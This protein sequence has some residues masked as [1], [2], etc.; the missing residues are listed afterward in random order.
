MLKSSQ[1]I[2]DLSYQFLES[3][4][5]K[6]RQASTIKRYRYDLEDFFQ[7]IEFANHPIDHWAYFNSDTIQSYIHHLAFEKKNKHRTMKRVLT[8]LNQLYLYLISISKIKVNPVSAVTLPTEL[9][10]TF[11]PHE[12]LTASEMNKITK[13]AASFKGLSDHQ[14]KARKYLI[15]RNQALLTLFM[16]YGLSLQEAAGL[17]MKHVHFIQNELM[18]ESQTSMS[19]TIALSAGN[20]EALF[21][22]YQSIP[23]PVRPRANSN[24]PLFVAFDF[25]RNTYR[26]DYSIERPKALTE[27][28]IQK[29]IRQEIARANVRKGIS[30]QHMRRTAV[31]Q[32][33]KKG[34]PVD[35]IKQIFGFKSQ[36]SL[37]RYLDYYQEQLK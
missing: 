36:L 1:I 22:Y 25:K 32:T 2:P 11:S 29:M 18:I 37:K 26:W 21:D 23:K 16:T 19:R 27:I 6:G 30:A 15:K 4:Q 12:F 33:I 35:Q 28:A 17:K 7:W 20:S 8:V 9:I 5:K 34:T 3:L 13:T 24:D 10:E 14:L 31:L